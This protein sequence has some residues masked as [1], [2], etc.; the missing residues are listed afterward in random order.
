MAA[1]LGE[2]IIA[3]KGV[4]HLNCLLGGTPVVVNTTGGY[5]SVLGG[6]DCFTWGVS[7][8]LSGGALPLQRSGDAC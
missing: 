3:R 7:T 8:S 6:K 1:V 5:M 2:F 4:T